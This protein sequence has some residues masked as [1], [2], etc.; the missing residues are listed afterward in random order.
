MARGKESKPP[1]KDTVSKPP[2]KDTGS[3][4]RHSP[5]KPSKLR[6][7]R[8]TQL[9]IS[10]PSTLAVVT[11]AINLQRR[12]ITEVRIVPA[13]LERDAEGE[14]EVYSFN[15]SFAS[16]WATRT[17]ASDPCRR[18]DD[19]HG[20]PF[21]VESA[22]ADELDIE[23][24]AAHLLAKE[25][26][27][28][29]LPIRDWND[30]AGP[31]YN[32]TSARYDQYNVLAD[33]ASVPVVGALKRFIKRS[34]RNYLAC[35]ASRREYFETGSAAGDYFSQIME[36]WPPEPL[37]IM[38]WVNIFRH[39]R[40]HANALHWHLHN[41]PFQGYLSVTSEGS[42]TSFRSNVRP[43][44]RWR[45]EHKHGLLFLLPGGT[46]HASTPWIYPE[47][48]RITVAF[49][50]APIAQVQPDNPARFH[51]WVWEELFSIAEVQ[52][53]RAAAH[54]RWAMIVRRPPDT[55]H[56]CMKGLGVCT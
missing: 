1:H 27:W 24:L 45:F 41:W 26:E 22:G 15:Q 52:A 23:A 35:V 13:A 28:M 9:W 42:G 49:N 47:R 12:F 5:R 10:L 51:T 44:R 43:E 46:L 14:V 29:Q 2:Q 31:A 17:N 16:S 36:S 20:V 32:T 18:V 34:A 38:C 3:K 50:I 25:G 7:C 39:D 19:F 33:A 30:K 21:S 40:Q 8:S 53:F 37:Y 56:A 4:L 11:L 54:E 48:P 55:Y 6:P